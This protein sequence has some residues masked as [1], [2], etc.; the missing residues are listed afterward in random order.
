MPVPAGKVPAIHFEETP[1][2][3]VYEIRFPAV[4]TACT[5]PPPAPGE[6]QQS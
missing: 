5:P 4:S 2:Q 3:L 6:S 1:S